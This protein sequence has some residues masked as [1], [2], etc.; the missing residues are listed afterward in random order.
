VATYDQLVREVPRSSYISKA[1]LKKALIFDNNNQSDQALTILRKVAAD[2]PGTPEA[3]QAVTTA[4]L[5]YIDLGQV[6]VYG[7]WVSTLDFVDV[8]DAELDD[9]AYTSAERQYLENNTNQAD[10][11]FE[12]YLEQYPNGQHALQAH[13]YAGQLAFAKADYERTIPHY[14]F[15]IAKERSEFTEQALARLG[16]V[17][18]SEKRYEEA[19]PV[20]K[21]LETEAD[22][23]QNVI[24][25][26]SN[27]MKSHYELD[28][29]TDA[30]A[31]AEKVLVNTK[32]DNAVKSDAQVIIARSSIITN[33]E[34]RAKEAYA[35]VQKIATGILAAEALYYDAYF[36][37]Q[38]D[39]F[40]AS[41]AAVQTL[42]RDYSGYK[43][44]G[45]KGLVLMAKNFYALKDS[46]QATY[47]LESVI[48]NFADYPEITEE[49]QDLL[50]VIKT[51]ASKTN[52]SVE[53]EEGGN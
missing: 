50:A 39:D 27:L 36:K 5:I 26:Q 4:K 51:E 20:L 15:V 22:F 30:V 17:L 13:F 11:L 18:L 41:N 42:A 29:Y 28:A 31:Y 10:R 3:L 9:A 32:I 19:V 43:E 14:Q 16:Q 49:A 1:L 23:P 35:E 6:D 48:K 25:A 38:A 37:N 53:Q 24:F 7:Q 40:E 44:Y 45:A 12:E 8:E 21:R 33:D 46:F 2:F 52:T 47:I 34:V